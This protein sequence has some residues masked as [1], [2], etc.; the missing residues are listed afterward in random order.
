M[1]F[2]PDI[3][4]IGEPRLCQQFCQAVGVD[5]VK[6]FLQIS[7]KGMKKRKTAFFNDG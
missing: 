6:N 1:A 3:V 5:P 2:S 7:V 4:L